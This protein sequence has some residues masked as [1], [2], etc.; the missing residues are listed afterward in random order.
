VTKCELRP[1]RSVSVC[2]YFYASFP[3]DHP[4]KNGRPDD[5]DESFIIIIWSYIYRG[6]GLTHSA[7]YGVATTHR[8]PLDELNK[9]SVLLLVFEDS[10]F[11][12]S[13]GVEF[14][15]MV[16]RRQNHRQLEQRKQMG[17]GESLPILSSA[18]CK[19]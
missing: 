19:G 12:P 7:P 3:E 13:F 17:T 11:I 4:E 10:P 9:N 14:C 18:S 8:F 5:V 1:I 16:V 6:F 2:V 15:A